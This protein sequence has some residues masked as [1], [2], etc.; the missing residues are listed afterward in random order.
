MMG[1]TSI[2]AY[3]IGSLRKRISLLDA[4]LR[5]V[6]FKLRLWDTL[7]YGDDATDMTTDDK[8]APPVRRGNVVYL[9][10]P[11]DE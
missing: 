1:I 9:T 11:D 8:P 6:Q 10:P 3:T 5:S 2:I 4:E 7:L